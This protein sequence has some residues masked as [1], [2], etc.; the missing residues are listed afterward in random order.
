M[1]P[2]MVMV[3]YRFVQ[4]LMEMVCYR[5]VQPLMEM[6]CSFVYS[7]STLCLAVVYTVYGTGR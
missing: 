7:L 1:L 2:L 3:C 4:P 6:V 5:F